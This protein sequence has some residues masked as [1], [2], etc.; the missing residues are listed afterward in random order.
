M[1]PFSGRKGNGQNQAKEGE[2]KSRARREGAKAA[3]FV[4][5]LGQWRWVLAMLVVLGIVI[6]IW[7]RRIP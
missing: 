5:D 3:E 1:R 4:A 6:L 7:G 2:K